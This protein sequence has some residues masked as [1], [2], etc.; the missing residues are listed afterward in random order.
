MKQRESGQAMMELTIML[1]ILS[2]MILA[3]VML[4]GIE[5]TGNA[6]LLSARYNAQEKA[7]DPNTIKAEKE[8][9]ISDWR[10][11][12]LNLT[13]SYINPDKKGSFGN[14]ETLVKYNNRRYYIYS[15]GNGNVQIPFTY[16]HRSNANMEQNTLATATFGMTSE[17][18]TKPQEHEYEKYSKWKRMQ[19][20]DTSFIH[21]FSENI[22]TGN[23]F[24]TANLV[25][26]ECTECNCA[27]ATIDCCAQAGP[28]S[29][30][31]AADV[32]YST[33]SKLF[34]VK[35]RAIDLKSNESNRVY[36]PSYQ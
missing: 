21:D 16:Q 26:G 31:D 25:A 24:N 10:Y 19:E 27:P 2:G 9:E 15:R 34:G 36:I 12:T 5:I 4:S 28:H 7:N 23:A 29:S 20:M 14:S 33:F 35:L 11:T 32:M 22:R 30:D 13:R 18:F 1:L 3:V 8:H 6:T 17:L